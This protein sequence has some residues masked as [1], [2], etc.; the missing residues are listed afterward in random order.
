MRPLQPTTVFAS[1]HGLSELSLL[2]EPLSAGVTT[3][4]HVRKLESSGGSSM[5]VRSTF[6]ESEASQL[7]YPSEGKFAPS[8]VQ[9]VSRES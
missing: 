1:A 6:V 3:E 9:Q 5:K 4:K 7:A 2:R 8:D